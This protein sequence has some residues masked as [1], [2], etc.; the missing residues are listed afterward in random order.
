M[1]VGK[2][3]KLQGTLYTPGELYTPVDRNI[4]D[5]QHIVT[6][7]QE[8]LARN[9]IPIKV[10]ISVVDPVRRSRIPIPGKIFFF[11]FIAI[12]HMDPYQFDADPDP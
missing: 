2:N 12:S 8:A 9:H 11:F 10:R 1:R 4:A 5:P 7:I 6:E 3:I